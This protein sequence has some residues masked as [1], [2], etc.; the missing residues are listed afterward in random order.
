MRA[1]AM[2]MRA[3]SPASTAMRLRVQ[4]RSTFPRSFLALRFSCREGQNTHT[5]AVRPRLRNKA[6]PEA[7]NKQSKAPA[8]S[9]R[10]AFPHENHVRDFQVLVLVNFRVH[11]VRAGDVVPPGQ[12]PGLEHGPEVRLAEDNRV[13]LP[14]VL[15]ARH[16]SL[17]QLRLLA[18]RLAD[19]LDVEHNELGKLPAREE[20]PGFADAGQDITAAAGWRWRRPHHTG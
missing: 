7:D 14:E 2:G 8:L 6:P 17:R 12:V 13:V 19:E 9:H 1:R 5:P 18:S 20:R 3:P 15:H 16:L 10:V 4:F 11:H